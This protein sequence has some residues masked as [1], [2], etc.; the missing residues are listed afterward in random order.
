[1]TLRKANAN[2]KVKFRGDDLAKHESAIKRHRQS[3]K[4]RERN[5]RVRSKIRTLIKRVRTAVAAKNRDVAVT[6]LKEANRA[7]DKAV[8][9]GALKKNTASRGISRL[10]RAVHLLAA[11]N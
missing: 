3:L 2:E 5:Q 7:L 9:K 10:A 6:Q 11:T 1:L 4:L 8:S